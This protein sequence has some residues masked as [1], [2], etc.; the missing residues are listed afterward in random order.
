M[1]SRSSSRDEP[2]VLVAPNW[3]EEEKVDC[4]MVRFSAPVVRLTSWMAS[5]LSSGSHS[6]SSEAT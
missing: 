5:P 6:E 3:C 2:A 1:A 4:E